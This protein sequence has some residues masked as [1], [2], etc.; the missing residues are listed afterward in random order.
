MRI[1]RERAD[2]DNLVHHS[3][4]H[5][6]IAVNIYYRQTKP[7]I[8]VTFIL[9][10]TAKRSLNHGSIC[11]NFEMVNRHFT[12]LVLL[13]ISVYTTTQISAGT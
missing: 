8:S 9:F 4:F 10:T 12:V 1:R 11:V 13:I 2:N 6:A 5:Y 7:P 3:L